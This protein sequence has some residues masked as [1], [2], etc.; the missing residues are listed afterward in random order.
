MYVKLESSDVALVVT[1]IVLLDGSITIFILYDFV[2]VPGDSSLSYILNSKV[3]AYKLEL[4]YIIKVP[5]SESIV[6]NDG[7]LVYETITL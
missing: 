3:P 7:T 6:T 4:G 1:F 5:N 2:L